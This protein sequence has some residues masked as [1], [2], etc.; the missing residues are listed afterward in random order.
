M[1]KTGVMATKK[2]LVLP[3]HLKIYIKIETFFFVSRFNTY[4]YYCYYLYFDTLMRLQSKTINLQTPKLSN[5]SVAGILGRFGFYLATIW[6]VHLETSLQI[7]MPGGS[8]RSE[9]PLHENPVS[10]SSGSPSHSS[11]AWTQTHLLQITQNSKEAD[12]DLKKSESNN[13]VLDYELSQSHLAVHVTQHEVH[14]KGFALAE[15]SL[16]QR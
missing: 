15:G 13:N 1:L 2:N 16:P 10:G 3:S 9:P 11:L 7:W 14:E 5:S 12:C 6:F 4:I 8:P